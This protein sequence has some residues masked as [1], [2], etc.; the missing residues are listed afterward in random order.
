[1][2]IGAAGDLFLSV[3]LWFIIDKDKQM[4]VLIDGPRAYSVVEVIA[5]TKSDTSLNDVLDET[6]EAETSHT[7]YQE[8]NYSL[9]GERMIA[10]FFAPDEYTDT[11][12]SD[13]E[14][15]EE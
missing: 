11:W 8:N 7:D 14:D 15:H 3:Q 6:V 2:I 9:V 1:M 5:I 4:V 10:Q 12:E 13:Y